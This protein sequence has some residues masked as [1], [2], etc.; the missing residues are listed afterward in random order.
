[1]NKLLK[2]NPEFAK[3][4]WL[5]FSP[6]RLIVMPVVIALICGLILSVSNGDGLKDIHNF[7]SVGFVVVCILWGMKNAGDSV[8]DEYNEKTWDWQKMS[9]TGS[10]RLTWGKLIGSTIYNWYGGIICMVI[11]LGTLDVAYSPIIDFRMAIIM[12]ISAVLGHGLMI[13]FSLLTIRK[14]DGKSKV[15]SSRTFLAIALIFF[16]G[17]GLVSGLS[18]MLHYSSG[19]QLV[20]WYGLIMPIS[21][22]YI[23]AGAFYC[24]WV[25]GGIYRA[26]RAELQ[27]ADKPIWWVV[28]LLSNF[29]LWFGVIVSLDGFT[30]VKS[31]SVTCAALC[32]FYLFFVYALALSEPKDIVNF[33]MLLNSYRQGKLKKFWEGI[34]LWMV[35][36]PVALIIGILAILFA[37]IAGSDLADVYSDY[38]VKGVTGA[39]LILLAVFAFVVRDLGIMLLLNFSQKPKRADSAWLIYLVILYSVFPFIAAQAKV[40]ALFYPDITVNPFLMVVPPIIEAVVVMVFVTHQWKRFEQTNQSV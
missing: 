25:V 13:L 16:T 2:L 11:Y 18:G 34:S 4:I 7:A 9:I 37:S 26:M 14:S 19:E 31:L 3:N 17:S 20:T 27:F 38:K 1:M 22:W 29:V 12:L 35:T 23:I 24:L 10:W 30:I 36:F 8:I 6:Q 28:F 32:A 39:L 5:E 33:R 40:G 15:K 21:N